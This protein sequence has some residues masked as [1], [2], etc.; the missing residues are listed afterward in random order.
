MGADVSFDQWTSFFT[1]CDK[2][3]CNLS[4][5]VRGSCAQCS[6]REV[7]GGDGAW[8]EASIDSDWLLAEA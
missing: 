3:H 6:C 7:S 2:I 1:N 4:R 5:M 8:L